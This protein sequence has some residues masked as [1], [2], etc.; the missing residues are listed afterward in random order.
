MNMNVDVQNFDLA[1]MSPAIRALTALVTAIPVFTFILALTRKEPLPL[2]G[3]SSSIVAV[4]VL[5]WVYIRP[6]GLMLTTETLALKF[7]GRKLQ[8]PITDIR[9]VRLLSA[10]QAKDELGIAVRIGLGGL[11]GVF[12]W[13][14]TS[15]RG[16]LD[17]YIT[18]L[19]DYMLIERRVGRPMLLTVSDREALRDAL[20]SG[21]GHVS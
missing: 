6:S 13:L 12:G 11:W 17:V 16:T 7:P 14:W 5:S 9:E 1:P 2:I 4:Y 15:R 20:E 3:L 19:D 10:Q 8:I 18:R 21:M